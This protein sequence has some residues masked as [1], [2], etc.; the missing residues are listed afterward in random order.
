MSDDAVFEVR[1]GAATD[2]GLHRDHNEDSH[3]AASPVFVVA[4]GMGGHARG[5]VASAAVIG[6]FEGLARQAKASGRRWVTAGDLHQTVAAASARVDALAAAGPAP[7]TTLAGVA[8]TQ[9]S[10]RPYWLA[11]NVGDSRIYVMRDDLLEQISVDHSAHQELLEAGVEEESI[12]IG[13]HVITRAIGG[14]RPGV[15][16]L[17]QWL[18]PAQVGDRILVCSD[19]LTNEVTD[20]LIAA[21]LR[22]ET[23]PQRAASTLVRAA[24]DAAGRDNV[25]AVVVDAVEV[26]CGEGI[27]DSDNT[28]RDTESPRAAAH[29]R[30]G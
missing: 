14:G 5:D 16:L 24:L 4:D 17:D 1:C 2:R 26:E 10:G 11:F 18:L 28:S 27:I 6:E 23:D 12:W 13:R 20:A 30:E 21:T 15:P 25:T 29:T 9:Q 8:L 7:G 19:G 22:C 3:L